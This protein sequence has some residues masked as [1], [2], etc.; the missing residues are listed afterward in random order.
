[1]PPKKSNSKTK[2]TKT[3]TKAKPKA[4]PKPKAKT[5]AK[6][7]PASKNE[8]IPEDNDM[9]ETEE[10]DNNDD[11]ANDS[12]SDSDN[13]DDDIEEEEDEDEDSNSEEEED[14]DEDE[15][16]DDEEETELLEPEELF[17]ED[18]ELLL[19]QSDIDNN[20]DNKLDNNKLSIYEETR[21]LGTRSKQISSG[22]KP[23]IKNSDH[24]NPIE[25]A[26]EE[27]KNKLAPV[28]LIRTMPNG[29]QEVWKLNQFN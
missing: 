21:V 18:Y 29:T 6:I 5:K 9:S 10:I 15:V 3:K 8:E 27:I 25:I 19:K 16:D 7:K 12:N 1:M 11:S 20:P 14:E 24:L 13:L 4:K 22:A 17:K 23:F 28:E 2:S 26:K